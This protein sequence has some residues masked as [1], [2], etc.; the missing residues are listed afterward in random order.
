MALKDAK[1]DPNR[2][3]MALFF[4]KYHKIAVM[5]SP[6]DLVTCIVLK[7]HLYPGIF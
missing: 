2:V 6:P 5:G 7:L 3:K 1:F 4:V